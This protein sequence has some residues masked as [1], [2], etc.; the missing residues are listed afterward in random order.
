MGGFYLKRSDCGRSKL[1]G[2]STIV[3]W[4][5]TYMIFL[6]NLSGGNR[7][8]SKTGDKQLGGEEGKE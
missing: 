7:R 8:M 4:H 6:I 2:C 3:D 5:R 1:F